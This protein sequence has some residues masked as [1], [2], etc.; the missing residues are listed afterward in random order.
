MLYFAY[1]SNLDPAQLDSRCPRWRF[2]AVARLD[3][4]RLAITR[5]SSVRRCG[6]AD[7]I[8]APGESV[9]GAIFDV[10]DAGMKRLDEAEGFAPGRE[11]NAYTRRQITVVAVDGAGGAGDRRVEV[12]TYI[13]NK[14]KSPPPPPSPEYLS[15]ILRGAR[16]WN[17]PPGHIARIEALAGTP[18]PPRA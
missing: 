4:H 16:H 13:A 15:Q 7:V 9:W 3:D 10:D 11:A 2:V 1:G 8:P 12:E 5:E 14:D 18:A 6:V 17:L